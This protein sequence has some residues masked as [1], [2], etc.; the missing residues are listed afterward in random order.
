[1]SSSGVAVHDDVVNRYEDTK[2][3]K[4]FKYLIFAMNDSLT[5]IIVHKTGSTSETYDDFLKLLPQDDCRYAVFDVDFM[6]DGGQRNKLTFFAWSPDTAPIKKK[7]IY[8]ASKEAIRRKLQGLAAEVQ[9]TD[10][11]EVDYETVLEKVSRC[12]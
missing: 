9:A 1:M 11:D 12:A 3:G 4:K 10:Y 2:I 6:K 8:A 5:E 7:M